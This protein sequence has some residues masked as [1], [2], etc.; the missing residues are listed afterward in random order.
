MQVEERIERLCLVYE[1]LK[2]SLV[3]RWAAGKR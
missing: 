1:Q 2:S 3:I